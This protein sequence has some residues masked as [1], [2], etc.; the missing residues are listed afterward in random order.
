MRVYVALLVLMSLAGCAGVGSHAK[1]EAGLTDARAKISLGRCDD[2]LV[3]DLRRHKAPELEQQA[4]YVCLQ[5]G[6]VSAVEQ[7]LKD[8]SKRHA[9]PPYPDY[10][11]YL[12]AL[13]QLARF[14]M[15]AD[16]PPK[17]LMEGRKAHDELTE[18]VRSYPDSDYRDGVAPR[19]FRLMEEM[20]QTEYQIAMTALENGDG[21][22]GAARLRY[23]ARHYGQ[24]N[25]GRDAAAW[26]KNNQSN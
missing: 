12:L 3:S 9:T 15:V 16:D 19:L 17:R 14:E 8:Y 6:E 10:S 20:A 25:A 1:N 21:E 5:Q 7:L 18:F 23:V 13:A 22:N 11:A 24:T 26:I 4:A 2:N